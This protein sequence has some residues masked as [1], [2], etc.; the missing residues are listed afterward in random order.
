MA[1]VMAVCDQPASTGES[2]RWRRLKELLV[3]SWQ[4]Q[5]LERE[6]EAD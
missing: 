1:R 6:Q 2:E 4:R 3:K 5:L